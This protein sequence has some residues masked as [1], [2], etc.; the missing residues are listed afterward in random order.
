M[1]NLWKVDIVVGIPKPSRINR[2]TT[3]KMRFSG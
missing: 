2:S 3:K 1:V